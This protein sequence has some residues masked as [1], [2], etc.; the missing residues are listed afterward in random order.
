[1]KARPLTR[2]AE[3]ELVAGEVTERGRTAPVQGVV[4]AEREL[5]GGTGG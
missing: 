5:V 3:R 2:E 1:M 4:R